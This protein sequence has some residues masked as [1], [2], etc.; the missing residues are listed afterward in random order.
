MVALQKT[1]SLEKLHLGCGDVR[2]PGYANI[3][4]HES[5]A[6]DLKLDLS[7]PL[8]DYILPGSVSEI[9]GYHLFEHLPFC[10]IEQV[11]T[12]WFRALRPGGK[13][14]LEMPDFDATVRRY[15]NSPNDNVILA[16]IFGSQEHEGQF[17]HW[18][19]NKIRLKFLFEG[20]GFKDVIFKEPT[21]YHAKLEPCLRCEATK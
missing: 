13:L 19:W 16:N 9:L 7:Y 10:R 1:I 14:I 6:V 8:P 5:K 15:L 3:D 4:M 11:V 21:D 20:V 12:S 17:H 2:L 18:G